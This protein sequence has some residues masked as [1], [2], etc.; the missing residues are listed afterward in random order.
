MTHGFKFYSIINRLE[1]FKIK[2]VF[3]H[4]ACQFAKGE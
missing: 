2:G 1:I 3:K 4:M